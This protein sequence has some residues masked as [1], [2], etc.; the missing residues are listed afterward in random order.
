MV[1]LQNKLPSKDERMFNDIIKCYDKKEY[2][3]GI[4]L[5]DKLLERHP[6]HGETQ[7]MKVGRT[8]HLVPFR[9]HIGIASA[10]GGGSSRL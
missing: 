4:E 6:A 10:R 9:T 7:S 1:D 8:H 2:D 5:C 3:Q